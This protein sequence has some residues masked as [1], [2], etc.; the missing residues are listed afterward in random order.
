LSGFATVALLLLIAFK[1]LDKLLL[2]AI[3]LAGSLLA[4]AY[5]GALG[6]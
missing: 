2:P 4:C 5:A 6:P 1:M 3:Y